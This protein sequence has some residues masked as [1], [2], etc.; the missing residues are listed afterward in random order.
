MNY[1]AHIYL[2][3]NNDKHMLGNLLGNFVNITDDIKFEKD[4][5]EGILMHR[6]LAPII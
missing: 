5:R 3:D 6:K 2:S 1:L 4:I